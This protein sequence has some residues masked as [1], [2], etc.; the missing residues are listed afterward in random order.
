MSKNSV[1]PAWFDFYLMYGG[2][3]W[4]P[5]FVVAALATPELAVGWKVLFIGVG[6]LYFAGS[7]LVVLQVVRDKRRR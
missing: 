6:A 5:V 3:I 1:V 4:G 2:I 7:L